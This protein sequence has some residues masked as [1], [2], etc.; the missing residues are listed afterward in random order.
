MVTSVPY[1]LRGSEVAKE[2]DDWD[3]QR[4]RPGDVRR[5]RTRSDR[6]TEAPDSPVGRLLDVEIGPVAH[7]GHF[8]ARHEGQ[9]VF[10]R[11]ALP[12]ERVTVRSPRT[13]GGSCAPTP[14]R[15]TSPRRTACLLPARTPARAGAAAA[16]SS[17]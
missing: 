4:A 12:G 9:V 7:G 13:A 16:T 5:G 8:V 6:V 2:R 17:T 11:H 1:Q 3:L 14:S 10:V 15:C